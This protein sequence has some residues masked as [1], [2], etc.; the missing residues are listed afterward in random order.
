MKSEIKKSLKPLIESI[1]HEGISM[2]DP[3]FKYSLDGKTIDGPASLNVIFTEAKEKFKG[4]KIISSTF[5]NTNFASG[6]PTQ[7]LI[8][9]PKNLQGAKIW[10]GQDLK[11]G[12]L[13]ATYD[14]WGS[15]K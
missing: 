11:P 15:K 3:I 13:K 1:I 12:D 7:V 4:G 10:V 14:K 5:S 2:A 6:E 8:G 9:I